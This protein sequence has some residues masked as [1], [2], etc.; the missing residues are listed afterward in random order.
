MLSNTRQIYTHTGKVYNLLL[1]KNYLNYQWQL[2]LQSRQGY[3][4]NK[5]IKLVALTIIRVTIYTYTFSYLCSISHTD[6]TFPVRL[7]TLFKTTKI[8]GSKIVTRNICDSSRK[9]PLFT[10]K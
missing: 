5:D 3:K 7:R 9:L 10:T 2:A 8:L 6:S 4:P 1:L